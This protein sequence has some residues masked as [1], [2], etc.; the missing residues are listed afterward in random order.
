MK[1]STAISGESVSFAGE[2]ESLLALKAGF[3]TVLGCSTVRLGLL[4]RMHTP[5][6]LYGAAGCPAPLVCLPRPFSS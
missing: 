1:A 2:I 3:G 6:S 5:W 4:L